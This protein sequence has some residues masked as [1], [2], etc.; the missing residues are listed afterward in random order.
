MMV[1]KFGG[2]SVADQR[3]DRALDRASCARSG[4]PR[5]STEGGDARGPIVVVSA[6]SGV[7]DRL[8]GVAAQRRRRR[9]RGRADQPARSARS[10]T[11]RSSKVIDD[12][13]LREQVV[14]FARSRVRRAR[15]HRRRRSAVLRE[16]S[17]RWLDAIAATGEILSSRIVAAA[18]TSHGLLGDLGRRAAAPSSPT[19]S[20]RRRRRCFPETTAALMT[21]ADPPLAAGRIPVIGGFVGATRERRDDDARPR[22]LGLLGGDRRRVPRRVARSR[23]GPTSTACSPPIRASS[24]TRRSCR[25][26]RSPKRPSWRTSAPRC[27]I[28]RR[29]SRRWRATF[30]SASSTRIAPQARGTLITGRAAAS[31]PAADR[32]R[33]EEGRHAS[34][35]SPRRAC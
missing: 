19:A 3:G 31:R 23:S 28:R 26:C 20:T 25:T 2:T 18:L 5:R 33:V 7:T 24:R 12:P 6:L 4:R 15:A 11:S 9:H 16:V 27:C 30:R 13:S 34:S 22:R 32:R 14:E 21:H 10:V 8:L 35:T 17:P 29:F 1:M